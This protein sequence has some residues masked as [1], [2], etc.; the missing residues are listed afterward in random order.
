M[1]NALSELKSVN[2]ALGLGLDTEAMDKT[3]SDIKQ[4]RITAKSLHSADGEKDRIEEFRKDLAPHD[5]EVFDNLEK[6]GRYRDI[7]KYYCENEESIGTTKYM[8]TF[9]ME[10][11][12]TGSTIIHPQKIEA[13]RN[14]C[15]EKTRYQLEAQYNKWNSVEEFA[16]QIR[17]GQIPETESIIKDEKAIYALS[18]SVIN[19]K[20]Y[21]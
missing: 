7:I 8:D 2:T 14:I 3:A 16:N 15:M 13:Y 12:N 6:E 18:E 21:V 20:P 9:L 4:Q 19:S 10:E 5:L 17:T 11:E 1:D